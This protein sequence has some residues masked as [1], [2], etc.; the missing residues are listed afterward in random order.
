MKG[1]AVLELKSQ[2]FHRGTGPDVQLRYRV[3][4]VLGT[5]QRQVLFDDRKASAFFRYYE[6]SRMDYPAACR[7]IG[8]EEQLH[9]LLR[10]HPFGDVHQGAIAK[11]RG[12]ERC[13]CLCWMVG[14][15][16]SVQKGF[17]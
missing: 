3:G 6:D 17:Q 12:V 11:T 4:E 8:N 13:E 15:G 10:R 14:N 2:V 7:S 9:R 5:A 1:A 16:N